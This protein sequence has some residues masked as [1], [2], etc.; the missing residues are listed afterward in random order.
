MPNTTP[1]PYVCKLNEDGINYIKQLLS[2]LLPF[3]SKYTTSKHLT[4][5]TLMW[6]CLIILSGYLARSHRYWLTLSIIALVGHIITDLLDGALSV[7]QEDGLEK[8]NF[9]M[10]H[11]LDFIF[12]ISIFVSLAIFFYKRQI[13][14]I[15]PLFVIFAMVIINMAASFLL[16]VEKGLDLGINIKG[17]FAFNIFHMH[18]L[19]IVFYMAI[20]LMHRK[21]KINVLI[22]W[23]ITFIITSLTIFNIYQK[24][25]EL[26]NNNKNNNI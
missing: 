22:I 23:V 10:D 18:F 8:W 20:I 24:Q 2:P 7:Y 19:M 1:E 6:A 16:V 25:E 21:A 11:L 3:L 5:C 12:A 9:F 4:M 13:K 15:T 14:L 26:A 17:C